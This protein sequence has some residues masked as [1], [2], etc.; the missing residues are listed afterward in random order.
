M[1][2]EFTKGFAQGEMLLD[3][4]NIPEQENAVL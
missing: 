1:G 4:L 3:R 2:L